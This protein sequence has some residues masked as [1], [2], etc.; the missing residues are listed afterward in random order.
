MG[1]KINAIEVFQ[2]SPFHNENHQLKNQKLENKIYAIAALTIGFLELVSI[3][4]LENSDLDSESS[5]GSILLPAFTFLI[6]LY[7]CQKITHS[8]SL[9]ENKDEDPKILEAETNIINSYLLNHERYAFTPIND[10]YYVYSPPTVSYRES[11]H[12]FS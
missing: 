9:K 4:Y 1:T 11:P 7:L 2:I 5:I 10:H 12:L 3:K 8:P 6:M